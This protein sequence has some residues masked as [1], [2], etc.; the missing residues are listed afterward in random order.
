MHPTMTAYQVVDSNSE[1]EAGASTLF[2]TQTRQSL[3]EGP[4]G[5]AV[6]KGADAADAVVIVA[7]SG[8]VAKLEA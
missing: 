2:S 6:G 7:A 4:G 5:M 8:E 3:P 1:V